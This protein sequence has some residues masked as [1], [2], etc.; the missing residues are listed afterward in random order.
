M[1][2]AR[3][4]MFVGGEWTST[5]IGETYDVVSPATGGHLEGPKGGR[6]D[7]SRAVGAMTVGVLSLFQ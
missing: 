5:A 1:L 2:T 4:R 6:E 7:A 3:Q